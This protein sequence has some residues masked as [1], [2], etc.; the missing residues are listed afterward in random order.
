[1]LTRCFALAMLVLL[2]AAPA[3]SQYSWEWHPVP[4]VW[5]GPRASYDGFAWY[6]TV[7]EVPANLR[8]PWKL[9]L[10]RIDDTDEA[11]INGVLIGASGSMPPDSRTA[12]QADRIYPIDEALITPGQ[13]HLLAVRVHDS[14]GA[15]GI[16]SGYLELHGSNG[17][18]PLNSLW[19]I[20]FG[21]TPAAATWPPGDRNAFIAMHRDA[22][23]QPW[24]DHPLESGP[25]TLWYESP[26]PT[27]SYALPIGNGRL[28]AMVF[29]GIEEERIQLNLDSL[30]AGPPYP[31]VPEDAGLHIAEARTL[32]FAGRPAEGEKIIAERVLPARIAPRSHQTLGDLTIRTP[33]IGYPQR[34][35]R[36]LDLTT[37]IAS[38]GVRTD[39]GLIVRRVFA[40]APDN[41]IV[42]EITAE[43]PTRF[44][45]ELSRPA[46]AVV[47][48]IERGMRMHGQAQHNGSHLGTRFEARTHIVTDG[49]T[50]HDGAILI[51]RDAT[52]VSILLAAETDYNFDNPSSPLT[53]D[54]AASLS[55]ALAA[56]ASRSTAER[57]AR[58]VSEHRSWFDRVHLELGSS[59]WSGPTDQRLA[60]VQSGASDPDLVE[61]YFDYARYLLIASSRPGSLPANLQG[62]WNEHLE[63][64]WNADY[65]TN[66]NLQMNYWIADVANLSE[67]NGPLFDF[68]DRLIPAG[69]TFARRLG[70]SGAAFGHETDPWFWAA[71]SGQPV[72]GMWVTAGGW[73]ASHYMEHHRFTQ[74]HEFLIERAIPYMREV[75]LFYL[76]WLVEDPATGLLVS[77]PTTSPENSYRFEGSVLSLSMGPT[78]DQQ[79]IRELFENTLEAHMLVGVEDALTTRIAE[80]LDKLAPTTIASNGR[81]MEWQHPFEEAEPGHRHM[82]HLYGL[83]PS[84]QITPRHTPHLAAAARRSLEARLQHGGGHTGWSR[85]WMINFWARLSDGEKSYEN[86]QLLLAKSTMP[87]LLDDHPP[88]QIDGN[89]GGGAGIAEMLLQSHEGMIVL[90]PALPKAWP[91]G[92]A[93]GLVAR[94]GFEVSMEWSHGRVRQAVIRARAGG[95]LR[96]LGVGDGEV[97]HVEHVDAALRKD[98]AVRARGEAVGTVRAHEVFERDMHAGEMFLIR[99]R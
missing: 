71:F 3:P 28:G 32:F 53:H 57:V 80:A 6:R 34:Y 89:F 52:H 83:H 66:I 93:R 47:E 51:A 45:F 55:A 42:I 56:A 74:N 15:G 16:Y 75:S 17:S 21:D 30:W 72:W 48:P 22:Q 31:V 76:D 58:H 60:R 25:R 29:G 91:D 9:H 36:Q 46:N 50:S 10:G 64:P 62:L 19:Q 37:A 98:A 14:G 8:G 5:D 67:L 65:H 96:L 68:C 54:L 99:F 84:N 70:C 78:M 27:W 12:W 18:V 63:A 95:T 85:A 43:Q 92:S 87:N 59:Q 94:G 2:A 61:L 97:F 44:E 13:T 1:M 11:F 40:S 81:I 86:I 24:T 38:T 35:R 23:P 20:H 26:A 4:A 79:I 41:V 90:L 82:S 77:G 7:I 49:H 69:R 33:S 88:F 73:M 39:R